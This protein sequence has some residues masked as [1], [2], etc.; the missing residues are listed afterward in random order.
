MCA[1]LSACVSSGAENA[2]VRR[3]RRGALDRDAL[4]THTPLSLSQPLPFTHARAQ[5]RRRK[6]G[7]LSRCHAE[8]RWPG[9]QEYIS[10][11]PLNVIS[12]A[13]HV[14]HPFMATDTQAWL[15]TLRVN[16]PSLNNS[17]CLDMI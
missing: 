2:A 9:Q 8:T 13:T 15:S 6:D 16:G 4:R 5:T 11:E 14:C 7:H 17:V 3:R 12:D 10:Q 1:R